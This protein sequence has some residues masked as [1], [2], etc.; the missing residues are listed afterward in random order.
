MALL[1]SATPISKLVSSGLARAEGTTA[2]GFMSAMALSA[3][4]LS[5]FLLG[6]SFEW[7]QLPG[8]VLVLTSI[9]LMSRV[10]ATEHGANGH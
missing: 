2:A 8:I 6:E 4:L 10:H 5:Y 7:I 3:L 9:G 1:G